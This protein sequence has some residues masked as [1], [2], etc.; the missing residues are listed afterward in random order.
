MLAFLKKGSRELRVVF[1][2]FKARQNKDD[3]SSDDDN[4]DNNLTAYLN[5]LIIVWLLTLPL[6]TLPLPYL[7]LS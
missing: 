6:L 7:Y 4:K 5:S 3:N 1:H 2:V